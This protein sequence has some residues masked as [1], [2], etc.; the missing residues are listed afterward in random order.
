MKKISIFLAVLALISLQ[1]Q[2]QKKSEMNKTSASEPATTIRINHLALYVADLN[3]S[4][5]FYQNIIGL[6]TIPEPF[7]DG[8]HTWFS[9]GDKAHLHLI[10]GRVD[11][12]VPTK[13]THLCF[14][15]SKFDDLISKLKDKQIAFEDWAGTSGGITKRVDGIRQIWF[16]DPDGYW[17]EVNDDH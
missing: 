9:I 12:P 5:S 7:K 6:K 8:K 15:T 14:S 4:T 17:I 3:A 16:R 2:A 11:E 13:N 10:A 1:S